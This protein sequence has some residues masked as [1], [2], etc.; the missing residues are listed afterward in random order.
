MILNY[1]RRHGIELIKEINKSQDKKVIV[2]IW[3]LYGFYNK[4]KILNKHISIYI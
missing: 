3:F 2:S 1:L 4:W